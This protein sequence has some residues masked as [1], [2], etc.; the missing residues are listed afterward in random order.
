MKC[1]LLLIGLSEEK[2][3]SIYYDEIKIADSLEEFLR[4][5]MDNDKYYIDMESFNYS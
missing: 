1:A 3:N 4:K 5:V 2:S